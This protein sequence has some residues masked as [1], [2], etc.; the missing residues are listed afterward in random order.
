M[1]LLMVCLVS[2]GV[3]TV[4]RFFTLTDLGYDL[5]LQIQAAQRLM[6]G[7]G[8]TVYVAQQGVLNDKIPATLTHFPA[9]YSF[10]TAGLLWMGFPLFLTTKFFGATFTIL[11]WWGW[12]RFMGACLLPAMQRGGLWVAASYLLAIMLPLFTTPHWNG[13]DIFLWAAVPWVLGWVAIAPTISAKKEYLLYALAGFICGLCCLMRYASVILAVCIGLIVFLQALPDWKKV[14]LRCLVFGFASLPPILIQLYIFTTAVGGEV[15]PGG[16]HGG[17]SLQRTVENVL[18]GFRLLPTWNVA[19]LFWL[20]DSISR[21]L[22]G[23]SADTFFAFVFVLI[24]AALPWLLTIINKNRPFASNMLD[25]KYLGAILIVT[26]PVF[27]ILCMALGSYDYVGDRRY[28]APLIPLALLLLAY[29]AGAR[30]GKRMWDRIINW[31]ACSYVMAFLTMCTLGVVFFFVPGAHG[32]VMRSKLMKDADIFTFPSQGIAYEHSPMRKYVVEKLQQEPHIQ[33]L[34]NFESLFWA[35]S[36]IDRSKIHRISECHKIAGQ[37][38][39]GP[40]TILIAAVDKGDNKF[41]SVNEYG[42]TIFVPCIKNLGE[43][44]LLETLHEKIYP[45]TKIKVL[46]AEIPHG[47]EIIF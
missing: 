4:M 12:G 43:M 13:T 26:V 40:K 1:K 35:D 45:A 17:H 11:G 6:A 10:Y 31:S 20:P 29:L 2:A 3:V 47:V 44:T 19:L 9:G 46:L 5:T 22:V 39:V 16:I 21:H 14:L 34:T 28:Y 36:T 25:L 38:I 37:K 7:E 41:Y 8:L 24:L 18:E 27:L 42:N 30:A 32:N 15:T 33:V 23:R